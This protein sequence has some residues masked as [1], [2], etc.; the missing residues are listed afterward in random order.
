MSHL[1]SALDEFYKDVKANHLT[2]GMLD[3]AELSRIANIRQLIPHAACGMSP[4]LVNAIMQSEV[5]K[6]HRHNCYV[7]RLR[8]ISTTM[9]SHRR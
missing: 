9:F 2:A 5:W 7:G 6:E 3:R 4:N 1:G 8:R